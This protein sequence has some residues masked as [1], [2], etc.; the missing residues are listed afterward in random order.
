MPTNIGRIVV[1]QQLSMKETVPLELTPCLEAKRE[2][3]REYWPKRGLEIISDL[4]NDQ[5]LCLNGTDAT[6]E[7]ERYFPS[8]YKTVKIYL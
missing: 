7:S 5:V 3:M 4:P 6:I 2:E 8:N 1:E